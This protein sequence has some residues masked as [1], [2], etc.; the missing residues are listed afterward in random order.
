MKSRLLPWLLAFLLGLAGAFL[1]SSCVELAPPVAEPTVTA[2]ATRTA[3]PLPTDT[4]PPTATPLPP[5]ATAT[6]TPVEAAIPPSLVTYKVVDPSEAG[7]GDLLTYAIIIMNDMMGGE[8][9]GSR[10]MVVDV[11]SPYL[12]LVPGSLTG[13]ATYDAAQHAIIWQGQ[14]A[15]G[16]SM[17]ISFQAHI[18][19]GLEPGSRLQNRALI[20]D[21]FG[22][23]SIVDAFTLLRGRDVT[24][25][26]TPTSTLGPPPLVTPTAT[27]SPTFTPSPTPTVS[28]TRT[29]TPL[30]TPTV[31]VY[32]KGEYYANRTLSGNPVLVRA[33]PVISFNWGRGSP[34]PQVPADNFSVRWTRRVD[35]D[36]ATYRFFVTVDDGVRL[37]INDVLLIDAWYDGSER[38]V[39]GT[40]SLVRGT[41]D[42]R[43]EYY[44]H[45]DE[46]LVRFW[47]EKETSYPDWKGEYWANPDLAGPSDLVRNDVSLNFD[48]GTG[49]P[50][51]G[52][53][54]DNFSA[55][56]TR[57]AYFDAGTYRFN[58]TVDD[59]V[60]VWVDGNLVID[61]WRDGAARTVSGE[62][63]LVRGTH[64]IRVEYYERAD[65]ARI[66]VW[67]ERVEHYPDWKGEYWWNRDLEGSPALVRNDPAIDFD[68]G[69]GAVAPNMPADNFSARWTRTLSFD[70]GTYRFYALADDVIRVWVDDR[71]IL[72]SWAGHN[73]DVMTY[74]L[75]LSAGLHRLR[76]EYAEHAGVAKVRFWWERI[77]DYP[78][79]KGEYWANP[80]LAGPPTLARND[81][82][83]NFDWGFG[84]PASGLPADN[85]SA[86]WTREVSFDG[87]TY[88]FYVR[89]N[90]AVRLWAGDVLLLGTWGA[91]TAEDLTAT[92]GLV[93][94]VH[95]IR[96]E[97]AD[98][99]GSARIQ[100]RWERIEEY[101]DWK[102]EYWANP[103]LAG[104]PALVRND[105]E[106]NFGWGH[107]APA[108]GLP[109]D[110]FS[111]R[112]TRTLFFEAAIYR[113]RVL[114][115]D[116]V[117]V[118]VG[119]SL[120]LDQWDAFNPNEMVV[121]HPITRGQHQIRVEYAERTESATV[122]VRWEP[123]Q[124]YPGWK[125]EY[126]TNP[127]LAGAPF[128]VRSDPEINFDWGQ[129][130][131]VPGMPR[132]HFSVRWTRTVI[133]EPGTYRFHARADDGIRIFVDNELVLDQWHLSTG[134]TYTVD[135][136][137]TQRHDLRVEYFD[138]RFEASV[139]VWWERIGPGPQ[140]PL[141]R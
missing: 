99:G 62:R 44:E 119:D 114:A 121:E 56:W 132:D 93:R 41:Y 20:T 139:S 100:L 129:G 50:A 9:P 17:V 30:P 8:D 83:I 101:P 71:L 135:V 24:P 19:Q 118:W 63:A 112:W 117:R 130:N 111:A 105:P 13:G 32:W 110:Y 10:V 73:P 46:A 74:D 116:L 35:F 66:H 2:T 72:D 5:L 115:D 91:P 31:F 58:A 128:L 126:F 79:W 23:I 140:P 125:G 59:G 127:D 29:Q 80:D 64:S 54:A 21:A 133:L 49:A 92:H 108:P 36:G 25:P 78:D 57:T 48:W 28:P 18:G 40:R 7:E 52:M 104:P 69:L 82:D 61:E 94:G 26:P 122:R 51:T 47:W 39:V 1:L 84:P 85:W 34:A 123:L 38:T 55:R 90:G 16:G 95:P 27:A 70:Q 134:E 87:G 109:V 97:Y 76:V 4:P 136:L 103:D 45:T 88:R 113:F 53:P 65:L 120:I 43:L 106:I 107:G 67:W 68:W 11:L 81:A 42:V 37:W 33:D 131:V 124:L 102:G 98:R 138:D 141:A 75:S 22:R 15:R 6:P 60:R 86:R 77:D 137:L 89:A 3:T 12:L 96:L 14:V